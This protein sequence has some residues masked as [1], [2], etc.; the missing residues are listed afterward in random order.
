M[1]HVT[2]EQLKKSEEFLRNIRWDVTPRMFFKPLFPEGGENTEKAPE[3][4][5]GYML[6][7][8]VIFNK[9]AVLIM[10][11]RQ[12]MSKTVGYIDEA[13]EEMLNEAL[14]CPKEEC[15][16]GMYPLTSRLKEWLKK[17]LGVDR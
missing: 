1:R 11:N 16:S 17:A 10:R 5:T 4:I 14:K 7:V 9:P 2:I 3:D 8:D 6:Y 15:V 12:Y 13:P